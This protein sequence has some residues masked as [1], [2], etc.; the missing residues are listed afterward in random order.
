MEGKL[1]WLKDRFGKEIYFTYH[2]HYIADRYSLLIDD[3]DRNI[4]NFEDWGGKGVLFPQIWNR[5]YGIENRIEYTLAE[6]SKWY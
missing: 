3:H 1:K 6:V 5:N 2:K 4:D